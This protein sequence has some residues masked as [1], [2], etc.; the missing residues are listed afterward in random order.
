MRRMRSIEAALLV[1]LLALWAVPAHAQSVFITSAQP[2]TA[3]NRLIIKGSPFS[4]G[5]HVYLFAGPIE[6]PVL[7]LTTGEIQTTLPPTTIPP[8]EYLLLVFQP[9]NG[10]FGTF[11]YT[12]GAMGP[13]GPT[14][15][16]GAPGATGAMGA[17]GPMGLQGPAGPPGPTGATGPQ[18]PPG[19]GTPPPPATLFTAQLTIAPT[20]QLPQL[21][22]NVLS[23]SWGVQSDQLNIVNDPLVVSKVM[24]GLSPQFVT[25]VASGLHRPSAHLSVKLIATQQ[26]VFA[27][28][29]T[30]VVAS[31]YSPAAGDEG[32]T[33]KI[34][35]VY[36]SLN[37]TFPVPA[38]A[39]QHD[40]IGQIRL[41]NTGFFTDISALNWNVT[42]P[43]N[44]AANPAHLVV[45]KPVDANSKA[46]L[47]G[48]L[49]GTHFTDFEI[50][51]YEPATTTVFATYKLRDVVLPQ[52]QL[53]GSG[54]SVSEQVAIDF[55]R[56][57]STVVIG[58]VTTTSCWDFQMARAC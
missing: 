31:G 4:A 33:E 18:G 45:L 16:T 21:Q 35:F 1:C 29:F 27:L 17:T 28:D 25:M 55:A 10:T 48:A 49:S 14:G 38:L 57:E 2:N 53:V 50:R 7:S 12:V 34:T 20:G 39:Y 5:M 13:P 54:P 43:P 36:G 30:D 58:G 15:E 37:S 32:P 3:Q 22:F 56:L 8:G 24:D 52:Y 9:G 19:P 46:L 40:A 51:L 26:E 41:P 6:L 47:Q 44:Q 23:F 42:T 11:P